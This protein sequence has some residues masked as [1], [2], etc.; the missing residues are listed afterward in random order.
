MSISKKLRFVVLQRDGFRCR[1]CG[2]TSKEARLEVDHAF[3][4]SKGGPDVASNLITACFDCNRGKKHYELP[5]PELKRLVH[6]NL[7]V[8]VAPPLQWPERRRGLEHIS[9]P[10]GR[11]YH[12]I[13]AR[14]TA[15]HG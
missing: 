9:A 8:R 1:Y 2:A 3:P 4:R 12:A 6:E 15:Q 14:W 5:I 10:L 7:P 13:D 11:I